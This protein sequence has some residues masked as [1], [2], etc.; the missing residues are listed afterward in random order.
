MCFCV[1]C[2]QTRQRLLGLLTGL[3][4]TLS[5]VYIDNIDMVH[6]HSSNRYLIWRAQIKVWQRYQDAHSIRDLLLFWN[7]SISITATYLIWRARRSSSKEIKVWQLCQ[8][9][10]SLLALLLF[11]LKCTKFKIN[12]LPLPKLSSKTKACTCMCV[13]KCI[14]IN[15]SDGQTY[16]CMRSKRNQLI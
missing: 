11:C 12:K 9:A 13:C 14:C 3:S 5:P 15:F 4:H 8:V 2:Q 1:L 10:N 16:E 6:H 7:V